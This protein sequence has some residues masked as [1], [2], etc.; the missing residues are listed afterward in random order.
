[1][2]SDKMQKAR[3]HDYIWLRGVKEIEA[4]INNP[5]YGEK[6]VVGRLMD[7]YGFDKDLAKWV[8]DNYNEQSSNP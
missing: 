5:G 2:I 7:V 4:I 1:M 6:A 8:F 3:L